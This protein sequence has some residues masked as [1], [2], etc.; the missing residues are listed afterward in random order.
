MMADG[1]QTKQTC[2]QGMREPGNR[3]P[4]AGVEG[5]EG[6]L[7]RLPAQTVLNARVLRDALIRQGWKKGKDLE[8]FEAAGAEHN[9]RAWE[10]RVGPMLKFLFPRQ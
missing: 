6:P 5:G 2:I 9:E 1:I 4:I 3:M 10:Q 7:N 8:Y